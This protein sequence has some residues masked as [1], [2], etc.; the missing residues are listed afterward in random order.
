MLGTAPPPGKGPAQEPDRREGMRSLPRLAET[1]RRRVH[2]GTGP[3]CFE[4]R[5]EAISLLGATLG[6]QRLVQSEESPGI[7]S[8]RPQIFPVDLLRICGAPVTHQEGT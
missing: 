6:S 1:G 4:F 7:P 5:G 8:I 3:G 2:I